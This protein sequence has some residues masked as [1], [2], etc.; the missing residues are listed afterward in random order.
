MRNKTAMCVL[1]IALV[2]VHLA[3]LFAGFFAPYD[4]AAQ[5]RDLS[6]APPTRIHFVGSTGF[7]WG[8]FRK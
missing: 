6:Y 2:L 5:N 3:L 4:P 7:H 8:P 1:M